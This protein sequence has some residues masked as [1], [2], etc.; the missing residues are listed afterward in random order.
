L[1]RIWWKGDSKL[2]RERNKANLE[3]KNTRTTA[4]ITQSIY[5]I[6]IFFLHIQQYT[7]SIL[8]LYERNKLLGLNQ[9]QIWG[10]GFELK[11]RKKKRK[12]SWED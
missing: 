9:I 2:E 11:R 3:N 8:G 7:N 12:K 4:A 5:T 10:L 6:F 1:A